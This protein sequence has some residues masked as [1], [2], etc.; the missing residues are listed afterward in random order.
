MTMFRK[1]RGAAR[2]GDRDGTF[3]PPPSQRGK[4]RV[5]RQR[6]ALLAVGVLVLAGAGAGIGVIASSGGAS[7]P[8][9]CAAQAPPL[10][11]FRDGAECV[12]VT[13]G[14]YV[15]APSLA[16]VE[17]EIAAQDAQVVREGSYVTVAFLT[18][19]T[20]T[21]GSDVSLGRIRDEL[22]GAYAAQFYANARDG[23][24]V[25]PRIRLVLANE[26][27]GEQAWRQVVGQLLAMTGP[28][29]GRLVAVIGMGISINQTVLGARELSRAKIPMIG[30]V[31]TGDG[32]DGTT[33]PGLA[34]VVPSTSEQVATLVRYLKASGG[35]RDAF[36][37]S[38]SDT[39]DIYTAGLASDF[40]SQ[41]GARITGREPFGPGSGIGD[42]LSII[43]TDVCARTGPPPLVIYAGRENVLPLFIDQLKAQADCDGQ[44]LTVLTGSDADALST[45]TT[46]SG[47]PGPGNPA[48]VSVIYPGIANLGKLTGQFQQTFAA[49][50]RPAGAGLGDTWTIVTY[51]AMIAAA[52]AISLA[53]GGSTTPP[54][55]SAVA[56][57]VL[58]LNG[59]NA[60]QGAAGP[61]SIGPEGDV[62]NLDIPVLRLAAGVTET[63]S[64]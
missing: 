51:N 26:G 58:L 42:E 2:G 62:T 63:L 40:Q 29:G 57:T 30:N 4:S 36:L 12:G 10:R 64:P 50:S 13:D 56:G 52:R 19:L 31:I 7:Q 54:K 28:G 21:A 41:F 22:N 14:S 53:D 17:R 25:Y 35:I 16:G 46:N 47:Q 39:S 18:P 33:I 27:S 43:A 44:D 48:S 5:R 60:V 23:E 1:P 38:D 55:A 20:T 61:F 9:L 37:V 32:L 59:D 24:A 45:G 6:A 49:T 11:V 3:R 8:V 15:F 34:R